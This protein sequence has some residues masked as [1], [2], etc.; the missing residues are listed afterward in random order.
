MYLPVQLAHRSGLHP[1]Q[2]HQLLLQVKILDHLPYLSLL[3]LLLP[4]LLL[5][6]K[7]EWINSILCFLDLIRIYFSS[8][9]CRHLEKVYS[10][11]INWTGRNLLTQMKLNFP[12]LCLCCPQ[13][14][15]GPLVRPL[16]SGYGLSEL[17]GGALYRRHKEK[18]LHQRLQVAGADGRSVCMLVFFTNSSGIFFYKFNF[19]RSLH[20]WK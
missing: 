7:F 8:S 5:L 16:P 17:G 2:N 11:E 14:W 18:I 9:D 12:P 4:C 20:P 3:L 19:A 1:S 10:W 13:W 15:S 6:P